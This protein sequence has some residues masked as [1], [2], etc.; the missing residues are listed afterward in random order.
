M[1]KG[2]NRLFARLYQLF[3]NRSLAL[4]IQNAY[5]LEAMSRAFHKRIISWSL[6]VLFFKL[7]LLFRKGIDANESIPLVYKC[8]D[9]FG[10]GAA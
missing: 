2:K 1:I 7:L 5:N 4:V 6:G 3:S 8:S 9:C 10:F